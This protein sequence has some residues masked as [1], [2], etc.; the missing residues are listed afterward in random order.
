MVNILFYVCDNAGFLKAM[1]LIKT[2]LEI[3]KFAIPIALIVWIAIDLFKTMVNPDSKDE[4]KKI[5]IKAFA[6][7]IVF[8]IPTI[9]QGVLGIFDNV[10]GNTDYKV[11]NCFSNANSDCLKKIDS[12]LNCDEFK[13]DA[14]KAACHEYRTCNNYKL[15][16]S[17]NVS[18]EIN[19]N[20]CSEINN[21]NGSYNYY[22]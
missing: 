7:I 9:V 19:D 11:S 18:T 6:A 12:Y 3:I 15:D 10:T 20:N 2:A 16:S 8:L 13:D 1:S 4:L 5:G 22:K 21:A 17:C 14:T